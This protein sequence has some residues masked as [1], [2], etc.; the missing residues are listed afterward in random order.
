MRFSLLL[1]TLIS[2]CTTQNSTTVQHHEGR[3]IH[4]E[5][6][7]DGEWDE[8]GAASHVFT[9]RPRRSRGFPFDLSSSSSIVDAE[10]RGLWTL[11]VDDHTMVMAVVVSVV[12]AVVVSCA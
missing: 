7:E 5:P 1:C 6:P 12:M 10:G 8:P 2:A 3:T 4:V 9:A 11:H